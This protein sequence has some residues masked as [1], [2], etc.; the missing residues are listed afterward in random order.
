MVLA[1]FDLFGVCP[2]DLV[3]VAFVKVLKRLLAAAP[4][5]FL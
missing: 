2:E 4:V 1:A 3:D 5:V